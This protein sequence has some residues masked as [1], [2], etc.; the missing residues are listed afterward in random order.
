MR[1]TRGLIQVLAVLVVGGLLWGCQTTEEAAPVLTPV[2][3]N[4]IG[5]PDRFLPLSQVDVVPGALE[6]TLPQ[7][8]SRFEGSG[9]IGTAVIVIAV[10]ETGRVDQAEILEANDES[11]GLAARK[12][13]LKWKFS[14]AV[15]DGRNVS[16]YFPLSLKSSYD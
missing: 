12:A 6:K 4:L 5:F 13:L 16:C 3:P 15:K 7:Y 2:G 9:V 11:F 10:S 1:T 8:P 14:P